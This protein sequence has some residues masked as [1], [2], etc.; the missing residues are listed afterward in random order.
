MFCATVVKLD[1]YKINTVQSNATGLSNYS[2]STAYELWESRNHACLE[3]ISLTFNKTR[4]TYIQQRSE[5]TGG[6]TE[7]LA[8]Q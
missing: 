2:K 1:I 3:R 5:G 7:R 4:F 8:V 6:E